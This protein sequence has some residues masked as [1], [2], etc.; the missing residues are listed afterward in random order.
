MEGSVEYVKAADVLA[1]LG[2]YVCVASATAWTRSGLD[3]EAPPPVRLLH[4]ESLEALTL[5]RMVDDDDARDEEGAGARPEVVVGMGGGLALDV[6]K[7]LALRTGREL[8]LVPGA[9][10]S[11]AAF[12][13][14]V[15]R[16]V[17]R[18]VVWTGEVAGR[19]VVDVDL[20]ARAPA[21]LNRAGAAE[22]VATAPA[23]WDWRLAD[24]RDKG[25]PFSPTVA[26]VG[27][28]SRAALGEAAEEVAAASPE[29]LRTLAGLLEG[30][31]VACTRAG[32]RRLVD[33][34]EHT[35]VQA[36]EHRLGRSDDYGA[37]LGLGSV[38]M[39]TLQQWY[40][41][42]AGGPVDPA[43]SIDLLSR[44]R[45]ASNPHQ[46]G[47]DEG[48]FRGLLRHSVRF[49][50]GE[51]LAWGVLDEA[52]VNWSAAEEM[53]RMCWRVPVQR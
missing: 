14:D 46:L 29:G 40:G 6:A 39:T 51:F 5:D 11:L 31:G 13:T 44:C 53:W 34:S 50:V 18:Q 2:P 26:E 38:A 1:A 37:R 10:S 25:L 49:H 12:T 16:R 48:T 47:L 24:A 4:P 22:I 33:G 8:V 45:V 19:V 28:A 9:L 36:Y 41:V 17:R 20:L 27:V 35:F 15:A 32:H 23:T 21:A 7:Y 3:T 42:S 52:D 30:L 43:E